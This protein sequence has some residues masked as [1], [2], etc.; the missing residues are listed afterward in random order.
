MQSSLFQP[1]LK[2]KSNRLFLVLVSVALAG[3]G[4]MLRAQSVEELGVKNHSSFDSKALERDPF[5]PIGWKKPVEV[6]SVATVG[7]VKQGPEIGPD[8]FVVSSISVDRIPLAVI[9]GKPYGEG[10]WISITADNRPMKL[11]ILSIRDGIVSLR[12]QDKVIK[13]PIRI[14]QKPATKDG[15]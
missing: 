4:G 7:P 2:V 5:T 11:Q 6:T 3:S 12:F 10:E 8:S 1:W 9:N 13:C 14:W 15:R